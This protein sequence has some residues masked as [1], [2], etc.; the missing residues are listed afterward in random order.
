MSDCLDENSALELLDGSLASAAR[1]RIERHIESCA[2][3]RELVVELARV[4]SDE[5]GGVVDTERASSAGGG[6]THAGPYR[7]EREVGRG[8]AGTIYRAVDERTGEVVAL[9]YVDDPAWRIRFAREVETLARLAHPGIVRYVGHGETSHGVYLAMEWLEGEGLEQHLLRGPLTWQAV[10]LL[11]LRLTS[12]LAHA[13]ASGAVHRDLSTRNVFLPRGRV[14]Q[15]KLLDF[16]LVRLRDGLDRTGSQA[17]LGTPFY[18]APEQV[19][20][21]RNV[22]ARADLFALGVLFYEALS[23][24]RPFQGDDLFTVWLKIV[25]QPAPDL[26]TRTHGVPEALL[27]LVE[28]LLAKDPAARPGSAAEVH[29]RLVLLEQLA[30]SSPVTHSVATR[31][32]STAPPNRRASRVFVAVGV[33]V[34]ALVAAST[35]AVVA[36]RVAY[37]S[38]GASSTS[39]G[40]GASSP[41]VEVTTTVEPQASQAA[42]TTTHLGKSVGDAG[43][44]PKGGPKTLPEIL[45]CG[46]ENVEVRRGGNYQPDP[47]F[48]EHPSVIV[49][50]SCKATLEDCVV[51]GEH[52]ISV[53]GEA[54]LTLRRCRVFGDVSLTGPVTLTLEGTTLSKPPT[55]VGKGR[56]I[57]H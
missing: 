55:I 11:G 57:R 9:K 17:V 18:M 46:G 34:M 15:A 8:S 38:S 3:C 54:E 48:K 44:W 1:A 37:R 6:L 32:S 22:D 35:L 5:T 30:S 20:D 43:S 49:S 23:G 24:V 52:S 13:H 45:F 14:D 42:S 39:S 50:G 28:H 21:P 36:P 53:L 56:I 19:K 12:A 10:R 51:G 47:A 33:G 26:R 4:D 40:I 2:A 16:G 27:R 41:S 7:I 29:Q 25:D 31:S